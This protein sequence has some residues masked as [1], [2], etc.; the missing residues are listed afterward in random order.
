MRHPPRPS[1]HLPSTRRTGPPLP[2]P[3]QLPYGYDE[4]LTQAQRYIRAYHRHSQI[5]QAF[6]T[7]PHRLPARP[8]GNESE[9]T[10]IVVPE[11]PTPTHGGKMILCVIGMILLVVVAV[12]WLGSLAT[13]K[14]TTPP[15]PP[16]TS[17]SVIGGPSLTA[18]FINQV[19]NRYGSPAAGKGQTL[20]DL[21][22]KYGV[23]P[24]F[25]LA[26]FMHESSFGKAG[27]A[28]VTLGLGNERCIEDRPCINSQG[29]PCESEQSCYAQFSSWE[30]GFEHWYMLITGPVYK[31]SGLTTIAQIIPRYA[32]NAD[33]NNEAGYIASVENAVATWRSGKV[34]VA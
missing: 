23:D 12:V 29:G 30:D 18:D 3:P 26:F 7:I 13:P 20:Y 15:L 24:A 1:S 34:V 22:V 11:E 16:D 4:A 8:V 27:M 28:T 9:V 10:S 2:V 21:G 5:Y 25:A 17:Y 6:G 31:G 33:H 19:L 14:A 32:P